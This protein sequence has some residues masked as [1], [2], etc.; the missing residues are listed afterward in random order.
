MRVQTGYGWDMNDYL[1]AKAARAN[2]PFNK[3]VM[4][5]RCKWV[6]KWWGLHSK[7]DRWDPS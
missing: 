1:V 2:K 5:L 7:A 6:Q 4:V 3:I